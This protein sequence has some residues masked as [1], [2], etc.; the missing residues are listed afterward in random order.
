MF[1]AL[2]RLGDVVTSEPLEEYLDAAVGIAVEARI[3]V[4]DALYLAQAR[5]FGRL[6]TSDERQCDVA[7]KLG[8]RAEFV[9]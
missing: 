3:A 1:E 6:L 9:K 5:N 2:K 7:R 4:Y 8:I